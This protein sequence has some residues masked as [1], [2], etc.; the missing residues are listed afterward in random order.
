MEV[1]VWW[2]GEILSEGTFLLTELE[3]IWDRLSRWRCLGADCFCFLV[4]RCDISAILRQDLP[5]VKLWRE[6]MTSGEHSRRIMMVVGTI[7][8]QR[9]SEGY[10]QKLGI[11]YFYHYNDLG[12]KLNLWPT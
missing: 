11:V 10:I 6:G 4:L 9:L 7:Q 1:P 3:R 12:G 2:L 5:V 8:W